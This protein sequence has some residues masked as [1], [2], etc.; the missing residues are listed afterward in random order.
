MAAK[1]KKV[2]ST[3]KP[4]ANVV[5]IRRELKGRRRRHIL[6]VCANNLKTPPKS[7]AL[8]TAAPAPLKRKRGSDADDRNSPPEMIKRFLTEDEKRSTRASRRSFGLVSD[9]PS[10]SSGERTAQASAGQ[11]YNIGIEKDKEKSWADRQPPQTARET[12]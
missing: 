11:L 5:S 8:T 1:K 7:A 12:K 10:N 9:S 4:K 2:K 6:S 3:I